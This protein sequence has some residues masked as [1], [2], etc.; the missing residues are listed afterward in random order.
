VQATY[1][2]YVPGK[3]AVLVKSGWQGTPT[4][5]RFLYVYPDQ[6]DREEAVYVIVN[7]NEQ[8][9][10]EGSEQWP[11]LKEVAYFTMPIVEN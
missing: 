6:N 2:N 7:I 1:V 4:R 3:G 10:V 5:M 11:N 8:C 9:T